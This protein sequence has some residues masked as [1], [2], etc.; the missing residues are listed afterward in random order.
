MGDLIK[1]LFVWGITAAIPAGV[2]GGM[3]PEMVWVIGL[4]AVIL[5]GPPAYY[6]FIEKE[7]HPNADLG[8]AICWAAIIIG[9][10]IGLWAG[11][12]LQ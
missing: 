3:L 4:S 9:A 5:I 8:M 10:E 7:P 6:I 2:V 12:M 11:Y 1:T